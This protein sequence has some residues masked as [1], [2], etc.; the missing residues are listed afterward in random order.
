MESSPL[1]IDVLKTLLARRELAAEDLRAVM[2]E[3]MNGRLADTDVAA[4]LVALRMKGETA[5]ELAT[6]AQVLREHMT[7]WD[8]GMSGL[9][10]T[11]G[12]GGDGA[13]TFNISTA[14]ALVVA[15]AGVPVVKHGNRSVSS[16][17]GSAD[18]LHALDIKIDGDAAF[19][20]RCLHETNFAF[21]YAPQFH[22]ALKHVAAIR[23]RLGIPTIFNCLG[24][25]A[26]PA[27]A[28]YQLLGVG[29]KDLLELM[30]GALARLGARHAFVLCSEDG[31]DEVS[32]SARTFAREIRAGEI[33]A[34]EWHPEDFGLRPCTLQEL[35]APHALASAGMIKTILD[36]EE[37]PA[38]RIVLANAAVALLAAERVATLG[39]GVQAARSALESGRGRR[40]LEALQA[41]SKTA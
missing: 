24:P 3:M 5:S 2:T 37:S 29:R 35:S 28:T 6:A 16:R 36:G 26:N 4:F 20:R 14:T 11:C 17:S 41:L 30:A 19:A 15:A 27:G 31:L 22:P 1:M 18:V 25:L 8:A 33:L 10:D 39:E 38:Q 23:R 21:C 13:G 34:E 32:L 9:L 7:C 12:T 40:V